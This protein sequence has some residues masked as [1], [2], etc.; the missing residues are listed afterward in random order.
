MK[1]ALRLSW[2][3]FKHHYMDFIKVL[4]GIL[5][6]EGL[7]LYIQ[8]K[9]FLKDFETTRMALFLLL[10]STSLLIVVQN[11]IYI[12]RER[13]ILNRDFFSGLSRSAFALASL[14]IHSFFA[15]LETF[16]FI[17]GFAGLNHL[18][19]KE[20][21]SSGHIMSAYLSEL[22]VTVLLVF[23]ASHFIALLISA[24]VGKSEITS[25]IL[26][27]VVGIMQFSL[28]GTI[29][30]LPKAIDWIQNAIYLGYGHKLAGVSTNLTDFP[31]SLAAF[32]VTLTKEELSLFKSSHS[33]F[34]G[35]WLALL[36]HCLV[37]AL[38]FFISIQKKEN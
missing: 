22:G 5:V 13:A 1:A 12:S 21:P 31:S 19:D 26:A 29:L 30:Q 36:L 8:D 6:F 25:V 38:L 32:G 18:F 9:G 14:L 33:E 2:Y 27:V 37:Y 28:S 20:L 24:I 35:Q 10:F 23:L 11:S 16:V 4:L 17:V 15:L 7:I 34:L 3:K